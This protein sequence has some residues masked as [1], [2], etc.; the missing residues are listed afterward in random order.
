VPAGSSQGGEWTAFLGGLAELGDT[1]FS[2]LFNVTEASAGALIRAVLERTIAAIKAIPSLRANAPPP[3]SGIGRAPPG[4]KPSR[5]ILQP[6]DKSIGSRGT[7]K[8]I[9]RL[10]EGDFRKFQDDLLRDALPAEAPSGYEGH[11]YR[12]PDGLQFGIRRSRDFGETIDIMN[13]P[14][15]GLTRGLK[16]H[17]Q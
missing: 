7:D 16:V 4:V 17:I 8:T 10:S 15:F 13:A 2:T 11:V 6:G 5:D 12:R 9:R 1:F 14:D 3:A